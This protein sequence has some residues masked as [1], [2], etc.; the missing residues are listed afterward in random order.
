VVWLLGDA[1]VDVMAVVKNNQIV[2]INT[3]ADH[4]FELDKD[5]DKKLHG[6]AVNISLNGQSNNDV[7]EFFVDFDDSD[8]FNV[9]P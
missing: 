5:G 1:E 6:R 4:L 2:F 8:S 7:I 3:G 9:F